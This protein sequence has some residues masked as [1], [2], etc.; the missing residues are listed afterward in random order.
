MELHQKTF[1]QEAC[2]L[3]DGESLQDSWQRPAETLV[4]T[5]Y[6]VPMYQQVSDLG[7]CLQIFCSVLPLV[8]HIFPCADQV[9][10]CWN[11]F[12]MLQYR[13]L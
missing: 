11:R 2:C 4:S 3:G 13:L 6:L 1:P 10:Q 9:V 5:F 7:D 12:H 8:E